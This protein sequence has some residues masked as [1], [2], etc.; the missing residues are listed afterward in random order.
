MSLGLTGLKIALSRF[1]RISAAF[2]APDGLVLTAKSLCETATANA[3]SSSP[4]SSLV[5]GPG[6]H[7]STSCRP[8]RDPLINAV[9]AMPSDTNDLTSV[10]RSPIQQLRV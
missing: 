9:S 4:E 2:S 10:V 6:I 8:P 5:L 1:A 7:R 3:P